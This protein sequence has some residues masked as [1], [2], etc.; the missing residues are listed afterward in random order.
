MSTVIVSF[1]TPMY[2]LL[3]NTVF[4]VYPDEVGASRKRISSSI[5]S[6]RAIPS[7]CV[8]PLKRVLAL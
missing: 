3:D 2:Y 4:L 6:V 7:R 8:S 5:T 1:F